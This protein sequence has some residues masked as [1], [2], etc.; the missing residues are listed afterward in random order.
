NAYQQGVAPVYV[1]GA[2]PCDGMQCPPYAMQQCP[3]CQ[4]PCQVPCAPLVQVQQP[5][6]PLQCAVWGEA[7]WLHPTGVDMAHAQQ[8]NG[9]GGAGT[10]PFGEIGVADP[11]FELGYRIGGEWRFDPKESVFG[12]YS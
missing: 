1:D 12:D 8:Q 2:N 10:V 7:L 4:V 6:P 3:P 5:P 11:D 9:I